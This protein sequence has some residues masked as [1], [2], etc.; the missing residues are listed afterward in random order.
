MPSRD[1]GVSVYRGVS[2]YTGVSVYVGVSGCMREATASEWHLPTRRVRARQLWHRERAAAF[3]RVGAA[4]WQCICV[5]CV[6][7]SH[8]PAGAAVRVLTT[9]KAMDD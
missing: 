2:V 4:L 7:R 1:T 9:W 6:C 8:V 3:R 5:R